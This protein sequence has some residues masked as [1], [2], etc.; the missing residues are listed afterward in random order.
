MGAL[1][2]AA[3]PRRTE[4]SGARSGGRSARELGA[5]RRYPARV[6]ILTRMTLHAGSRLQSRAR[7]RVLASMAAAGA[8][9]LVDPGSV[10]ARILAQ[11]PCAAPAAA[12]T[13][14]RTLPLSRAGAPEQP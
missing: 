9:T 3:D 12:G 11:Q 1:R 7:R 13:L 14:I 10:L 6:T 2:T 8:A 4:Q 5:S